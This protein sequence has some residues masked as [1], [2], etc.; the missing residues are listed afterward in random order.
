MDKLRYENISPEEDDRKTA[1]ECQR[2]KPYLKGER[3]YEFRFEFPTGDRLSALE[4]EDGIGQVTIRT[5]GKVVFDAA[6]L[7]P[8]DF[9][10]VTPKYF[11]RLPEEKVPGDYVGG[12]WGTDV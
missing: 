6:R 10:L 8:T 12:T 9:K 1:E 4:D 7:L 11:E 5:A 3:P 2:F